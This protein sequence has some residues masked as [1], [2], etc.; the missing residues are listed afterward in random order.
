MSKRSL[1]SRALAAIAVFFGKMGAGMGGCFRGL[2]RALRKP[3]WRHGGLSLLLLLVLLT[4]AT[5]I[6]VG[7]STLEDEYSWRR[8]YSFNQYATTSEDT[9]RVLSTLTQDVDVYAFY[10]SGDEDEQLFEVLSRY[11]AQ[12]E[13]VRV[14]L[15]DIAKNPGLL[16]QYANASDGSPESGSVVVDCAGTGRYKL[17][18]YSQFVSQG[19]NIDSGAIE[20]EGVAYEKRITEAIVYVTEATVP[21]VGFAQSHGEL[22]MEE[23]A[24]FVDL[25][26]S[27]IYDTQALSALTDEALAGVDLLVFASP[28][29][30]LTATELEALKTYLENGGDLLISRDYTDSLNLPNYLSL[31]Q[32][33]GITPLNGVMVA[34]ESDAES[35]SGERVYLLPYMN[36][37]DFTLPLIANSMDVLMLPGSSAF[38]VQ[39]ETDGS[40]SVAAVLTAADSAYLRSP[41]NGAGLDKQTGDLSGGLCVGAYAHRMHANGNVS[42]VFAIGC[43]AA[44]TEETLYQS[45]F[46]QEFW[47]SLMGDLMPQKTVSLDIIAKAAFRPN[48]TVGSQ[49][50]GVALIIALPLLVLAAALI[51]LLPRRNR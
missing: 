13:H 18:N 46:I 51:V 20:I 43:S 36:Q 28:T 25:L 23:L 21:V 1:P 10:S 26:T 11:R 6:N 14:H 31:L 50:L 15:T 32:N 34:D 24:N 41:E 48:L 33:Y 30:D 27:N 7:V 12:S 47:I 16:T 17:L 44:L 37:V 40:L 9:A 49:T 4:A 5:L 2:A 29:K 42:R 22:T 19:Y 45:T 3:K 8:D 38:A 39:E 35:Y